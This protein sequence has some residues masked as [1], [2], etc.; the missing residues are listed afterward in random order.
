MRTE[1]NQRML[2][3]LESEK[4]K[5]NLDLEKTKQK[6]I[7]ELRGIKKEDMFPKPKK[8]TLWEKIKILIL[9]N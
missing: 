8:I 6:I 9:G 2:N 5:D 4:K 1:D 3:W 7:K